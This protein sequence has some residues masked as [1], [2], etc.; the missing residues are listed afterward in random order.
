MPNWF[1][2]LN[3]NNPDDYDYQITSIGQLNYLWVKKEMNNGI[4]IFG[5]KKDGKFSYMISAIRHDVW[6]ENN[7]VK[8]ELKK[9]NLNKSQHIILH[10]SVVNVEH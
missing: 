10:R 4:I 5:G 9:D 8:V 7:R 1:V 3:G 2:A 6:A